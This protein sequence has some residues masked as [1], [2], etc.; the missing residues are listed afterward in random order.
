MKKTYGYILTLM[1]L[2]TLFYGKPSYANM[3]NTEYIKVKLSK[4]LIKSDVVN[5]ESSKGFSIYEENDKVNAIYLIDE[6]KI[7]ASIDE[8]QNIVFKDMEDNV[9]YT[10]LKD[11]SLLLSSNDEN[12]KLIKIENSRYRGYINFNI[13]GQRIRLINHVE[14]E[15][16]LYGLVPSEMPS[17]FPIEA[18]KAQAVAARTYAIHNKTKHIKEGFNLCDTTHCQVYSGY[19]VEK[20][21]TN[22][23]VDE[24]KGILAYYNG[25]T[26]DA[27]YHSSSSGYT[28]DSI[29][30]WGGDSPYLKSV[31]D[32]YSIDS[33]YSNWNT[34]IDIQTLNERIIKYGIDIGNLQSIDISKV[35]L[36]GNVESL[37]LSGTN[38]KKEVKSSVFRNIVGNME[39]KSTSFTIKN[40]GI[41]D[42]APK[43]MYYVM[44]GD[45][46]M[47]TLDLKV[48]NVIDANGRR[49]IATSSNRAIGIDGFRDFDRNDA[50]GT[51]SIS[52]LII[53]GKGFGHGVGMSQYGAKK[54]A[55]LGFSFKEI[56][57]HYY[58]GIDVL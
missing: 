50:S 10:I 34:S 44:D 12:E 42:N 55:E 8:F 27:Q 9:I 39:L 19:D 16:Y 43:T 26:I 2:I 21:S 3:E 41:I 23:A 13:D 53:E 7:K 36:N 49:K 11:N 40:E 4:P 5:L 31:K 54:M 56:L 35:S 33:P 17:G 24:T 15:K 32:E 22:L 18:L 51:Q 29:S 38:G 58:S 48:C 28:N 25:N 6:N 47:A 46:N 30:V 14:I 37:I 20:P 57:T 52:K 45:K 1:L